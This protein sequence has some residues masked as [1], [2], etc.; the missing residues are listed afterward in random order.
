MTPAARIRTGT[1]RRRLLWVGA[2]IFGLALAA[3]LI[4][5]VWFNAYL[6]SERFRQLISEVTSRR[7][8][9]AGEYLPFQFTGST[10]YS[11][12]FEAMGT[13]AAPFSVFRAEQV[14]AV[15]NPAGVLRRTWQVDE[16]DVQRLEVSFR[17]LN[18]R[19]P[20]P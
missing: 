2:A 7:L 18:R 4:G 6:R 20:S 5:T 9:A 11:E 16:V 10:I 8:K 14:R 1:G 15:L 17:E 19:L 12:R 13:T 3:V